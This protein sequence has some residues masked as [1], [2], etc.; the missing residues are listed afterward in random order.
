LGITCAAFFVG[1]CYYGI[2]PCVSG[3]S[4]LG[5]ATGRCA[6]DHLA[7]KSDHKNKPVKSDHKNKL[8][9]NKTCRANCE[10]YQSRNW[11]D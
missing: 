7:V 3:T 11:Y 6:F 9:T 5:F 4:C 10:E 2:H 1:R 8:V